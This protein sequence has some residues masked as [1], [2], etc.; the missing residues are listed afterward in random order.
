M[1]RIFENSDK[2]FIKSDIK[3]SELC[4][5]WKENEKE[6]Y[7]NDDKGNYCEIDKKSRRL[8]ESGFDNLVLYYL[9]EGII[10]GSI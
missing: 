3:L 9:R 1:I 6:F 5:N 8:L 2:V 10:C 7:I 4:K